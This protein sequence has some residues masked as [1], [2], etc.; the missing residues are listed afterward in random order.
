MSWYHSD[1]PV[2][3]KKGNHVF[4]VRDMKDMFQFYKKYDVF[5]VRDMEDMFQFYKKYASLLDNY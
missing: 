2:G 3:D 4:N 5:N 1:R